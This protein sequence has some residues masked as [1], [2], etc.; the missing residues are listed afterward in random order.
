VAFTVISAEI[1]EEALKQK[2]LSN[3]ETP[4][5]IAT[6]PNL[7]AVSACKLVA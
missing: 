1:D 4:G 3:N 7:S 6:A 5:A 2:L